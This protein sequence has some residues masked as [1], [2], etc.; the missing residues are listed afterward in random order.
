[1]NEDCQQ[2]I[3]MLQD[4]V[5]RQTKGG[6]RWSIRTIDIQQGLTPNQ[7]G[8]EYLHNGIHFDARHFFNVLDTIA[9]TMKLVAPTPESPP[10]SLTDLAGRSF[11]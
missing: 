3:G 8:N 10:L 1:M 4:V 9:D 11:P 6:D 5:M 2:L 7:F